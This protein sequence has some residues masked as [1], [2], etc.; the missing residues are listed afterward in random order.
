MR[1]VVIHEV[2]GPAALKLQNILKP[3]PQANQVRI[4]V[5]SFGLNRSEVFT[6]QGYSPV[7]FP[8][9]LGIEATGEID[10]AGP[11]TNFKPGDVVVTAMGG[12][13]RA[14]DG[15][16]AEYVV[17]PASQVLRINPTA[18]FGEGKNIR[19][20]ILGALPELMQTTW[21]SLT[22]G[23]GLQKSDR[24]LVRGGTS[25]VGLA[26]ITLAKAKWGV[27]NVTATTRKPERTDSL[28]GYGADDVII[29]S[30][31]I[32]EEVRRKFP[33][34]FS[35]VL[36]LVGVTTLNDSL[37]CT[38]VGGTVCLTGI[39]GG[40]WTYSEPFTPMG[41]IPTG[42]RLTT[43]SGGSDDLLRTPIESIAVDL[44]EG[45]IKLPIKTFPIGDIVEAH[46]LLEEGAEAK[47]VMLT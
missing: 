37:S 30:G 12:M 15:G 43:Y 21:G 17:V 3:N 41:T 9:V 11:D 14:F 7:K 45:R 20:D 31:S 16:Y 34:G 35:K 40:K 24:L 39:V 46:R 22:V 38:E 13:G 23:L 32:A 5:R 25:S 42:V 4:R 29:D 28:K 47:I 26:A 44:L 19:W 8:R 36:E 18:V 1:A 10:L 2:G 27:S 6:R 33:T